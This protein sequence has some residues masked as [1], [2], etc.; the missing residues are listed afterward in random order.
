MHP[1]YR[2]LLTSIERQLPRVE[3][4]LAKLDN[5]QIW[6]RPLPAM[7]SVGNLCLHLAGNVNHYVG[8]CIGRTGYERD[9]SAEFEAVGGSTRDQL[10]KGLRE[11]RETAT[12]VITTLGP[13]D[14]ERRIDS[15][16]PPNATVTS[17]LVHV[18]THFAYHTGQIVQLTKL[19]TGDDGRILDWGH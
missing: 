3:S 15:D 8:A 2:E 5:A 10:N 6:T 19:L 12:R 13:H 18:G 4:C 1:A 11:A 9:R 17:V 16:H 14:I 7:N